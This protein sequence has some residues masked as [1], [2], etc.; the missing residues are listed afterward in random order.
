MSRCDRPP[1]GCAGD[2]FKDDSVGARYAPD[3]MPLLDRR[4]D[5]GRPCGDDQQEFAERLAADR[6]HLSEPDDPEAYKQRNH[7]YDAMRAPTW[8]L[9]RVE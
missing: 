3:S 1:N 7:S 4:R 6:G 8:R 2:A 5:D 9:P